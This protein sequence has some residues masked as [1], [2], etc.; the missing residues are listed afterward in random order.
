MLSNIFFC[1]VLRHC[2]RLFDF[3]V[4]STDVTR[5]SIV[6]TLKVE[7][8]EKSAVFCEFEKTKASKNVNKFAIK[9]PFIFS[10]ETRP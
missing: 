5:K 2:S 4:I 9:R 3:R 10:H 6:Y 7:L 1:P 8:G